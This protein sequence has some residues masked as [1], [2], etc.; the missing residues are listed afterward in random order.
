MISKSEKDFIVKGIQQ[1]CRQDGRRNLDCSDFDFEIGFIEQASGSCR[2]QMNGTDVL[3][4]VKNSVEDGS[5][6]ADEQ[7]DEEDGIGSLQKGKVS[8]H[9]AYSPSAT[10]KRNS[11]LIHSF[12]QYIEKTLNGPQGGLGLSQLVIIPGVH[13]LLYVDILILDDNGHILDTIF[14]AVKG[15]LYNTRL[16]PVFVESTDGMYDFTIGDSETEC[17]PLREN[18]P[19][20]TTL[21]FIGNQL[22]LDTDTMEESLDAFSVSLLINKNGN[23]CGIQTFSNCMDPSRITDMLQKAVEYGLQRIKKLDSFLDMKEKQAL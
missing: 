12:S 2:L 9:I 4:S 10:I 14:M 17:L 11:G 8:C 22:V 20:S 16:P 15:A 6:S 13:W 3:V 1:S 23:V 7:V 18:I 5:I 19:I 21:S